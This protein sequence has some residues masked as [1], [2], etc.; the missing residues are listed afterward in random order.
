MSAYTNHTDAQLDRIMEMTIED[1]AAADG[2]TVE[3]VL[4]EGRQ[5]GERV[6]DEMARRFPGRF[7]VK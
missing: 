4:E 6:M 5:F 2:K 1:I 7:G 3:Q